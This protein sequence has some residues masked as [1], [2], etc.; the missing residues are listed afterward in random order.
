[1]KKMIFVP[2]I[3]VL[4]C[5]LLAACEPVGDSSPFDLTA[6]VS[7]EIKH[8]RNND[9]LIIW[10]DIEFGD[11]HI[12]EFEK[13]NPGVQ[14]EVVEKS[15]GTQLQD[16]MQAMADDEPVDIFVMDSSFLGK[17]STLQGFEDLSAEPY[18]ADRFK[19]GV[20]ETVWNNHLSINEDKL[21]ALPVA[22]SPVVL[23]YRADLMDK[24]GFPSNSE[25]L[26]L[27]LRSEKNL[28]ALAEKMKAKGHS[29][30][31]WDT[32]AIDLYIAK[33]GFL[34]ANYENNI[35]EEEFLKSIQ[36]TETIIR[37]RYPANKDIWLQ[38]GQQAIRN[39]EVIM[40]TLGSWGEK[41]LPEF[42]PD[43][44]GK[45]RAAKPPLSLSGWSSS[46]ALAIP[47]HSEKKQLAWK[48]IEFTME[49]GMDFEEW[50]LVPAYEPTRMEKW[51]RDQVNPYFGNQKTYALYDELLAKSDV[52]KVTPFDDELYLTLY[53]VILPGIDREKEPEEIY[54]DY[55]KTLN[56]K[57]GEQMEVLRGID[58]T[59]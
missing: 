18:N 25:A 6:G 29:I 24:Y 16:Y 49:K 19:E 33:F 38:E 43:Q 51:R 35:P 37:N 46:T 54:K 55:I 15:V 58:L 41:Y 27:Y 11:E 52:N 23:Y 20:S 36:L 31:L 57:Y 26:S 56:E 45:W 7:E 10:S 4:S 9:N 22:L 13:A 42:A 59:K 30:F 1:M 5:L 8:E 17:F 3:I 14:V 12:Q 21:F 28:F 32:I 39:E 50:P 44:S 40:L 2:I 47:S 48:F 53:N 34:N